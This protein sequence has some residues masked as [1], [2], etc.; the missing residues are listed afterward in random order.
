MTPTCFRCVT[1]DIGEWVE[2]FYSMLGYISWWKFG[3]AY[4][5]NRDNR[6]T[7]RTTHG[8][9]EALALAHVHR[10]PLIAVS[11]PYG[12]HGLAR[13]NQKLAD[14]AGMLGVDV[15]VETY[16]RGLSRCVYY[17][18]HETPYVLEGVT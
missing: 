12:G 10:I 7:G 4:P 9:L 3:G 8:M 17:H 15:V 18:D 2:R 1:L 5:D 14:Y 13:M 6:Q 16:R 11:S